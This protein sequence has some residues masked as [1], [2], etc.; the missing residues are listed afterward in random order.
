M[1]KS[2]NT[3]GTFQLTRWNLRSNAWWVPVGLAI[4]ALAV[5]FY[6]GIARA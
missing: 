3:A 6:P 2:P 5:L 1:T 4:L